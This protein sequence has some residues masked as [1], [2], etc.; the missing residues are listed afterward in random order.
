MN[1]E[2]TVEYSNNTSKLSQ[3]DILS[4]NTKQEIK[5]MNNVVNLLD[6]V[7]NESV[8]SPP[9][10]IRLGSD[11]TAIIPFTP[12]SMSVDLHYCQE[13]EINGYVV[14]NGPDCVLCRIGRKKDQR[15][16]L[17]VYLPTAG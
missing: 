1:T 17:P 14:C 6:L 10:V 11:E 8:E 7:A 12:H 4:N 13:T 3:N 9:E 15:L 16:L 2:D 5:N